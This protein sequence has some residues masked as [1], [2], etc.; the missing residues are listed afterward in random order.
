ME[1]VSAGSTT[2]LIGLIESERVK[3][4]MVTWMVICVQSRT[5]AG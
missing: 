5:E 3:G 2:T 4:K 1:M